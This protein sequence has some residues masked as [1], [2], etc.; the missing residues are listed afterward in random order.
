M[1]TGS[2]DMTGTINYGKI[3]ISG[4]ISGIAKSTDEIASTAL[5][6]ASSI[7]SIG[8]NGVAFQELQIISLNTA[9]TTG[10][11]AKG[12]R[13][14]NNQPAVGSPKGWICTVAGTPGTWV[15]EGN[16]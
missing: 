5:P 6:A 4:T 11:W 15:S 1:T 13:C 10:T 9:P 12:D 14:I 7:I 16:L 2:A 8:S 3:N